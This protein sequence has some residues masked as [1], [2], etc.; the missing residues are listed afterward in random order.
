MYIVATVWVLG[1]EYACPRKELDIAWHD[2]QGNSLMIN[3]A[4]LKGLSRSWRDQVMAQ[5]LFSSLKDLFSDLDKGI[6]F[7]W[8]RQ[9]VYLLHCFLGILTC[10]CIR[11]GYTITLRTQINIKLGGRLNCSPHADVLR[12]WGGTRDKPKNVFVGGYLTVNTN[13]FFLVKIE[14]KN[15][16]EDR[17]NSGYIHRTVT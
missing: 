16:R 7:R 10:Q 8:R 1:Q 2:F 4:L 3:Q 9:L 17:S 5:L 14:E 12:H 13:I 11:T 15:H 6:P